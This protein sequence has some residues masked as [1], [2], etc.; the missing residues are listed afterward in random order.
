MKYIQFSEIEALLQVTAQVRLEVWRSDKKKKM[1][2]AIVG[3]I[4]PSLITNADVWVPMVT[5]KPEKE[6]CSMRIKYK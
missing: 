6:P 3:P 1:G 2:H 5:E 4:V